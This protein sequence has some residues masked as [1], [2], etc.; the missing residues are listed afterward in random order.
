MLPEGHTL[1]Y[2]PADPIVPTSPVG[3]A[4]HPTVQVNPPVPHQ[5]PGQA[6]APAQGVPAR[7]VPAQGGPAQGV[8]ATGEAGQAGPAQGGPAQVAAAPVPAP[9]RPP[10]WTARAS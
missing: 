5:A 9:P 10:A 8:P 4:D 1:G 3:P 2:M 7:G 6:P